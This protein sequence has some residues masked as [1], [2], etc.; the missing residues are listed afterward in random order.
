MRI[1]ITGA[2][3]F[4]GNHLSEKYVRE[5]N[6]VYAHDNLMNGDLNNIHALLQEEFQVYSR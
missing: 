4:L 1:L 6:I 3:G 2:A 5:D